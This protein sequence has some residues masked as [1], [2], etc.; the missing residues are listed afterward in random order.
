MAFTN[1]T[2]AEFI[3]YNANAAGH[4]TG[5][6][7]KRALSLA[8]DMPY[9]EIGKELIA[10]MKQL[11]RDAWNRP[12]VYEHVIRAH[13]G[14]NKVTVNEPMQ[15]NEFADTIGASGTW[16]VTT[17]KKTGDPNHI[18][19]VIDGTIYDS[20]D[21]TTQYV[22]SYFPVNVNIERHFTEINVLDYTKEIDDVANAVGKALM[23][24]YPWCK[25]YVRRFTIET[26]IPRDNKYKAHLYVELFLNPRPYYNRSSEYN[27]DFYVVFTPSTT[28][29]DAHKIIK[30]TIKTRMYDRFYSIN[31]QEKKKEEANELGGVTKPKYMTPRELKFWNS[32]PVKYQRIIKGINIQEPGQWH[33]SYTLEVEPQ[34]LENTYSGSVWLETYDASEMRELL[35]L[36]LKDGT[37][38]LN[39]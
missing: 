5:D 13:G 12:A 6:C 19:C 30:N 20:W 21:S 24:K 15:L 17:G 36:Y 35:E 4:N 32:L 18:V 31:Q 3:R 23:E 34:W 29:E 9:N 8:F 27:F 16:L 26:K 22:C 33:D 28:D 7:V 14:G 37:T 1:V 25:D 2:S 11:R 39:Y 38:S 10:K